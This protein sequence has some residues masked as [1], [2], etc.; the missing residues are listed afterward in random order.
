MYRT[1]EMVIANKQTGRH[2][3]I[4]QPVAF[5][6]SSDRDSARINHYIEL[7]S[8]VTSYVGGISHQISE[9]ISVRNNPA[10]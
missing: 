1:V 7:E 3:R 8:F 5:G 4:R 10:Q 9:A 2:H 6:F